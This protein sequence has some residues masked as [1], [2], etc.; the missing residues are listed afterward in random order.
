MQKKIIEDNQK[1]LEHDIA[2]KKAKINEEINKELL[3]VESEIKIL[4]KNSTTSISQIAAATS[5]EIIKQ[6]MNAEVNSSSVSAFVN[7]II[8]KRIGKSL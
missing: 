5:S 2:E 7:E 4:K 3:L 1:K 8:K 6:I